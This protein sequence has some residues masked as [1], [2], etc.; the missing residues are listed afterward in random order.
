MARTHLARRLCGLVGRWLR[1]RV[2][3]RLP[4]AVLVVGRLGLA[5][6]RGLV[7][8]WKRGGR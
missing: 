7:S 4:N 8:G 3:A 6:V 1:A 5:V 2:A